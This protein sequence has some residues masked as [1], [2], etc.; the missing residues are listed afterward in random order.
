MPDEKMR[1]RLAELEKRL[2]ASVKKR[3][4]RRANLPHLNFNEALPIFDKK[5]D[6][7]TAIQRHPVVV[8]SGETGSSGTL[9]CTSP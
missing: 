2:K 3:K 5:D 8:V 6:I 9:H 1:L 7:I 4:R